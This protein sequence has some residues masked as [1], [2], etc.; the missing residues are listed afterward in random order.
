MSYDRQI[1]QFC[2]HRVVEEALFLDNASQILRPLRPISNANSVE[3]KLNGAFSVP[4]TGVHTQAR[5]IGSKRGPFTV[6]PGVNDLFR[7]SVNGEAEQSF[8]APSGV[9]LSPDRLAELLS[10]NIRGLQFIVND[11]HLGFQTERTGPDATVFLPATC[12]LASVVGWP[13]PRQWRGKQVTPGWTLVNDPNTLND[14]PTRLIIFDEPLKGLGDYA[15]VNYVTLQQECRRCGGV[16]IE[17]DWIYGVTG[18]VIQVVDDALLYQEIQK[19][20]FTVRATNPFFA[21]YGTSISESIGNKQVAGGFLQ[22]TLVTDIYTAFGRW[23]SIKRQQEEN[24]GQNVS[25]KEF[26]F[27]LLSV[28]LQQ[29]QQD[30]TVLFI[31]ITVQNRSGDPIN[32]ERGVRLPQPAD[33]LGATQAQGLFAETLRKFTLTG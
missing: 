10:I 9:K 18:E 33:L 26:P 20:I 3:V 17:N 19:L 23:Q 21:W 31:N 7:V 16:G 22:N 30:P 1:Q 5:A 13:T 12:T 14:R 28:N 4:S 2:P 25:D 11:Q 6:T 32:I 24:V 15:E 29:S 27:R 8:T